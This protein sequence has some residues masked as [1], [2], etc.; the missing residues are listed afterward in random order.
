MKKKKGIVTKWLEKYYPLRMEKGGGYLN[1]LIYFAKSINP[2]A[3]WKNYEGILESYLNDLKEGKR[4]YIK[5]FEAFIQKGREEGKA[6]VTVN[7]YASNIKVFFE[8][9]GFEIGK[10][11]WKGIRRMIG[12]VQ[13]ATRDDIPT[14][15]ELRRIFNHLST[16]GKAVFYFMLSTGMR[17]GDLLKLRIDDLQLEN[18]PPKANLRPEYSNKNIPEYV[19]MSYEARDAI[20]DWLKE[21]KG[22]LKK[23]GEEFPENLLFGCSYITAHVMWNRALEKAGLDQKDPK[24]GIRIFHIHTLRKYFRTELGKPTSMSAEWM[25]RDIVEG[26]MGHIE[27]QDAAYKRTRPEDLAKM[28]REHMN[29]VMIYQRIEPES[30]P[31]VE[32]KAVKFKEDIS[33][34]QEYF[35]K[36]WEYQGSPSPGIAIIKRTRNVSNASVAD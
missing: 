23:T 7:N 13:V 18:D 29:N 24:T 14:K 21:K 32:T 5:D 17:I 11:D 27:G 3:N 28:Y 30:K 36:G 25:P 1:S 22:R 12:R 20:K 4:N 31:K 2:K 8:D 19:F 16:L 26:L 33:E 35:D 34:L 6:S 9:H 15:R 10:K